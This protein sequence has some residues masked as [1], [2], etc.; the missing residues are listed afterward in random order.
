M[1]YLVLFLFLISCATKFETTVPKREIASN[2]LTETES[3]LGSFLQDAIEAY[4][5]HEFSIDTANSLDAIQFTINYN[6][7]DYLNIYG[8]GGIRKR[9]LHVLINEQ[10]LA[11]QEKE[12]YNSSKEFE[13]IKAKKVFLKFKQEN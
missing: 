12:A 4:A 7:K 8:M 6:E 11:I 10:F 1:K 5:H 9:N 2:K 3:Y 13:I